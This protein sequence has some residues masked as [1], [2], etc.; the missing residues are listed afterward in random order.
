MN[1][2]KNHRGLSDRQFAELLQA[3]LPEPSSPPAEIL[4]WR[5]ELRARRER[6]EIAMQPLDWAERL[7]W[8]GAAACFGSVLPLLARLIR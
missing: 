5:A 1:D 4:Y 7:G 3:G 2:A 8:V 6:A